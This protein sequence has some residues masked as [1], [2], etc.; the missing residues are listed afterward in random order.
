M[1]V[2]SSSYKPVNYV[3]FDMDGLLLDTERLYT[4]AFQE[5]CDPFGKQYT[6]AV[7]SSV[8]GKH[9]LE[10]CQ[11]IRDTLDIPMSAEELLAASR[12]IQ[13]RL[14][15]FAKLMPG[16]E[17]LLIHLQKHN[18]PVAVATSSSSETFKLKTSQHKDLFG[19][20]DHVV[21]GDDPEVK[22]SKPHPDA[23]LVCASR[24]NPP[25]SPEKSW[26]LVHWHRGPGLA[27]STFIHCVYFGWVTDMTVGLLKRCTR[28]TIVLGR[29]CQASVQAPKI[30][31]VRYGLNRFK[32][33]KK[34]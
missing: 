27:I 14:F 13:E 31:F 29:F 23:F 2:A 6:W 16:V 15:P 22:N 25:A 32:T 20:F 17:K 18:I 1:S 12:Q 19:L 26:L 33:F 8:M 21:L 7:K 34:K 3:I 28:W 24:F 9:A 30:Q 11:I 5:I 10:A 4:K